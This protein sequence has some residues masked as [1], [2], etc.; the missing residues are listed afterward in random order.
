MIHTLIE[1]YE[2][3]LPSHVTLELK[4][5]SAQAPNDS[6]SVTTHSMRVKPV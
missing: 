4:Q 1:S 5:G 3:E 6:Q 2:S